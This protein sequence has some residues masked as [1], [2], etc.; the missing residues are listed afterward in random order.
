[1]D[2]QS[3]P[4]RQRISVLVADD[5]QL[6]RE[7]ILSLLGREADMA[8]EGAEDLAGVLDRIALHG[9]FDVILLDY[10]MPGVEGLNGVQR[11]IAANGGRP[12]LLMS[13]NL[14]PEAVAGAERLG[15]KGI[16]PKTRFNAVAQAVRAAA[17]GRTV[18]AMAEP[19]AVVDPAAALTPAQRQ[20]LRDLVEGASL[21]A[22]AA[23]HSGPDSFDTALR[24]LFGTLGV[25]NRTHA[26]LAA[27]RLGLT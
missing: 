7:L 8:P 17:S 9:P 11:A 19:L 27:R 10:F 13:G 3:A 22:A 21:E 4:A 14:P 20:L 24:G 16:L 2:D 1:M 5:Q 18:S 26:V 15:I 6:V 12:V 23:R 25:K